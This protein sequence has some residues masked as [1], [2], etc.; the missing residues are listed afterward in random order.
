MTTTMSGPEVEELLNRLLALDHSRH[1]AWEPLHGAAIE[2][3]S[4]RSPGIPRC[5]PGR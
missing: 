1:P 3:R 4:D 2:R 5:R